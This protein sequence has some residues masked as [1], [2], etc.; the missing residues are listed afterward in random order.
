MKKN[1]VFAALILSSFVG[2]LAQSYKLQMTDSDIDCYL[3]LYDSNAYILKISYNA[4]SD[5]MMSNIFSFGNYVADNSGT[6]T[7][8][9][10]T[11][12]FAMTMET[13]SESTKERVLFVKNSFGWME[14]NYFVMTSPRPA[15]P[16]DITE[17][18]LKAEEVFAF[19]EKNRTE[20][21]PFA[22]SAGKY[23]TDLEGFL[24]NLNRDSTYTMYYY[25]LPLSKGKWTVEHNLLVLSDANVNARFYA[26]VQADGSL[27]SALLPGEFSALRFN[28][29]KR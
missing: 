19:R 26:I 5:L 12:S 7:F 13:A 20:E 3:D 16:P 11:H 17:N 9:D 18:F 10:K 14:N 27:R 4:A 24:L 15:T 29:A 6:Y 28:A 1:V 22:I 23:S 25:S 8:T 2:A 21:C